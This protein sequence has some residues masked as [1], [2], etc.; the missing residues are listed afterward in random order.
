MTRSPRSRILRRLLACVTALACA[1]TQIGMIF[2]PH[3]YLIGLPVV[4]VT[5]AMWFWPSHG[6]EPLVV[7]KGAQREAG[8]P[9]LST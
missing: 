3:A 2:R 9:G 1:G 7:P 6:P 4:G 8:A 5:L